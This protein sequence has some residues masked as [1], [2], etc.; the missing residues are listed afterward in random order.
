ML[1]LYTPLINY[2]HHGLDWEFSGG[3]CTVVHDE[4]KNKVFFIP[5]QQLAFFHGH[6]HPWPVA[7]HVFGLSSI[8]ITYYSHSPFVAIA[9]PSDD[10]IAYKIMG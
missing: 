3:D 1:C 2:V 5:R 6:L 9:I 8:N 7:S 4:Y 10:Q